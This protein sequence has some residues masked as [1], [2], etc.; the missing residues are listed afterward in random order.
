VCH[1]SYPSITSL[2]I[3]FKIKEDRNLPWNLPPN[4]LWHG[5]L[6]QDMD[7]GRE[8][9][10]SSEL[11]LLTELEGCIRASVSTPW[12]LPSTSFISYRTNI[13]SFIAPLSLTICPRTPPSGK[14]GC[15]TLSIYSRACLV[16]VRLSFSPIVLD[17]M[18][19]RDSSFILLSSS[20]STSVIILSPSV[21]Y[22]A[23]QV[24]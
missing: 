2:G 13:P 20:P 6:H 1:C 9:L 21:Q 7:A 18:L 16:Y 12:V 10:F 24:C 19:T 5:F 3:V 14:Y 4:W 17:Y 23:Y 15:C 8:F 22:Y 11:T